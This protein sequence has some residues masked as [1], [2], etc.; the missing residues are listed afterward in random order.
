MNSDE[1]KTR[2][3]IFSTIATPIVIAIVG[4]WIQSSISQDGLKKDYVQI[5]INILNSPESNKN[6][7]LRQWAVNIID[8]NSPIPFSQAS[9]EKLIQGGLLF[10]KFPEELVE[11]CPDLPEL[12]GGAGKDVMTWSLDVI[13]QYKICQLRHHYTIEAIK[14]ME[15]INH[16]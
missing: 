16:K 14:G 8:K 13:H 7:E 4:W 5:A 9:K 12:K 3:S 10:V 6:V 1:L 11:E 15:S 2:V